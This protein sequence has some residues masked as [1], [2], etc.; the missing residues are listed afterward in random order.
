MAAAPA[1]TAPFYARS[2]ARGGSYDGMD[3]QHAQ[4]NL[5]RYVAALEEMSL[6]KP[7]AMCG[8][9]RR[10]VDSFWDDY[11]YEGL[12]GRGAATPVGRGAGGGDAASSGDDD[13]EAEYG[14]PARRHEAE[15]HRAGPVPAEDTAASAADGA[16]H[17]PPQET[18]A[19]SLQ[20]DRGVQDALS[21]ELLRM[22]SV[23]KRNSAAFTD[24]LERDRK[25]V[26]ETTGRLDNNLTLMTR[27][28]GQLG[29][30]SKKARS[31]GWF[32]VTS[33]VMVLLSWAVMF[34]VIRL[35]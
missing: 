19:T 20:S 29:V 21:S 31:M 12:V 32:T 26:E 2:R 10:A 5:M 27:T 6:R 3:A 7:A 9:E 23:L 24:A 4:V 22:A 34:V 35:T 25:L 14:Q 33:I 1:P 28:R 18:G 17:T 13:L 8:A 15:A 16:P 11:L 30:F